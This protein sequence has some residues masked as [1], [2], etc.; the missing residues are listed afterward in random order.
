M[1]L[2][3]NGVLSARILSALFDVGTLLLCIRL[4]SLIAIRRATW[5]ASVLLALLP[6]SVRYSQEVNGT[7]LRKYSGLEEITCE[8]N[9][10][11]LPGDEVV[12]DTLIYFL[13]FTYYNTTNIQ[14]RFH[15]RS[16]MDTFRRRLDRGGMHSYL[17]IGIGFFSMM[18]TH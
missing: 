11:A 10:Q 18:L 7:S 1:L 2:F 13:P 9:R 4:M 12:L 6:V 15:I 8:I 16:S 14:P 17:N 3:G 5:M